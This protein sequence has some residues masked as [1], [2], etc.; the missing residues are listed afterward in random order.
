MS[1]SVRTDTNKIPTRRVV[2]LD[3]EELKGLAAYQQMMISKEKDLK[4]FKFTEGQKVVKTEYKYEYVEQETPI[5]TIKSEDEKKDDDDSMLANADTT[6]MRSPV[7]P[8][9]IPLRLPSSSSR[10]QTPMKAIKRRREETDSEESDDDDEDEDDY[11]S[12]DGCKNIINK[13]KEAN[14]TLTHEFQ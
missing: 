14:G 11:T 9:L 13:V 10:V 1:K 5:V 6:P 3:L 8:T 2:E 7:E 4:D 12:A